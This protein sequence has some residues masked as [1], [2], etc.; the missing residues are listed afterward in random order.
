VTGTVTSADPKVY[1]AAFPSGVARA[2]RE[3]LLELRLDDRPFRSPHCN[4]SVAR[5]RSCGLFARMRGRRKKVFETSASAQTL[6][7]QRR[8]LYAAARRRF[9]RDGSGRNELDP[10]ARKRPDERDALK[11]VHQRG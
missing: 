10:P 3:A 2:S 1:A 4:A 6:E 8:Q 9:L 11:G 7:P 5:L